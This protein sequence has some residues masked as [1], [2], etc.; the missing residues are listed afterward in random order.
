[1]STKSLLRKAGLT[2]GST[3]ACFSPDYLALQAS[4]NNNT[5]DKEI[6]RYTVP[7]D[8][9]LFIYVTVSRYVANNTY[10]GVFAYIND[11][12]V[13]EDKNFSLAAGASYCLITP[14]AKKGQVITVKGSLINATY[15]RFYKSE[16]V[17]A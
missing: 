13:A 5:T 7:Y 4:S 14:L 2:L 12:H 16:G 15:C 10:S 11:Q 17:R 3:G 6:L 8:G 9:Y 1:M